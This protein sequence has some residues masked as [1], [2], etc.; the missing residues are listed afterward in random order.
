MD[1]PKRMIN[2]YILLVGERQLSLFLHFLDVRDK[3]VDAAMFLSPAEVE[4][5]QDSEVLVF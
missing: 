1:T 2:C 5:L 4:K 3:I